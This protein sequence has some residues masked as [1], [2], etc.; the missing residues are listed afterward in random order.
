MKSKIVVDANIL[1]SALLKRNNPYIK[2]LLNSNCRF[3]APKFIFIELFKHKNKIQK[4]SSLSEEEVIEL[5]KVVIE[6][7]EFLSLK[8]IDR[9]TLQKGYELCKDDPLDAPFV[10]LSLFL[11]AKLWT[12]DKKLCRSLLEKGLDLCISTREFLESC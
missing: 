11:D 10:A 7:I 3:F 8:G 4:F 1:F 6:N 5:L 12:G 9:E 2:I